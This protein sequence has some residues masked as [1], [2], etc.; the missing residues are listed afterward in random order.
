MSY[1]K[2][3][4]FLRLYVAHYFLLGGP[5]ENGDTLSET[6]INVDKL[7]KTVLFFF[8]G[9]RIY[10]HTALYDLAVETGQISDSQDLL[11]P[12]F[13]QSESISSEEIVKRVQ[14]HADG[15]MNWVIGAGGDETARIVASMYA[16]G[17]SGPLWEYLIQ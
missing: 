6:L 5:G 11:E 10:P 17:H 16:R 3:L 13:Y 15:R 7:E 4:Q 9:I 2:K 12:V 14:H 1:I 8:C